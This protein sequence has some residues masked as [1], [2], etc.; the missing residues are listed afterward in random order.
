ME[1]AQ[2]FLCQHARGPALR[3][4]VE[5]LQDNCTKHWRNGRQLCEVRSLTGINCTNKLHRL[6]DAAET[7]ENKSLP[8]LEHTS[9][10]QMKSTCNCGRKQTERDDPFDHKAAN[11]DFY[12]RLEESCCSSLERYILPG[13]NL[14]PMHIC[15]SLN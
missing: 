9:S 5:Q 2:Q 14:N 12:Q 7:D 15:L 11:Y 10:V 4:Y 8:V 3:K 6:P 13:I 1:Q